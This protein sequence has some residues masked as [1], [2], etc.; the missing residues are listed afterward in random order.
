MQLPWPL[1][2]GLLLRH[3]MLLAVFCMGLQQ[4]TGQMWRIF[5]KG[6]SGRV[7]LRLRLSALLILKALR[8]DRQSNPYLSCDGQHMVIV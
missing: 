8:D 1:Q 4:F 5:V 6:M 2:D 7:G 3:A